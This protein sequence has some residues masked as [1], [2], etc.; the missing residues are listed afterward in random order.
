M[1]KILIC[2]VVR[3]LHDAGYNVLA[4]ASDQGPTNQKA[5]AELKSLSS[6]IQYKDGLVAEWRHLIE[7][8]KLDESLCKLS[9]LTYKHIN[10]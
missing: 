1:L 8:F 2:D 5:V 10:P 6:D 4:T 9:P 7:F 3:A